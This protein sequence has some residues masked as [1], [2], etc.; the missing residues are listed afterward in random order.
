[1]TLGVALGSGGARGWCHIGVLRVLDE[2]GI[3]PDVVAGCSMGALVGA[4]WAGGRLDALE[5]WARNLSQ[6]DMVGYMDLRLADG[7]VLKGAAIG[8]VLRSLDLPDRIENLPKPFIVVATD[9]ATG[10][11]V[12]LRDGSLDHA[13]RASASIPG[14]FAPQRD[15]DRFLLDGGLTNPIPISTARALGARRIIGVN[16]NAKLNR[17][18]WTPSQGGGLRDLIGQSWTARLPSALRG[19]FDG[20]AKDGDAKE[21]QAPDMIQVMSTSIDTM[22]EAIG[23]ARLAVDPA[24]V[25]LNA[26]ASHISVLELHRADEAIAAGRAAAEEAREALAALTR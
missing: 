14:V 6:M 22:T 1:M 19:W 21:V 7:G 2:M 13:V 3:I 15:G 4:A 5:D 25:M 9:M 18:L 10:R 20:D 26:D 8:E 12:W 17:P 11:E 23:R 24:D 16:P